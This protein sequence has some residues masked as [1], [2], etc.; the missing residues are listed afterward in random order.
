VT[1][2]E[3]RVGRLAL[4]LH[5]E[6]CHDKDCEGVNDYIEAARRLL[7]KIEEHVTN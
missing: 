2:E 6:F 4:L 5:G 7:P 1:E 3:K